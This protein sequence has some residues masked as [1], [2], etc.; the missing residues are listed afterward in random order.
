MNP[1]AR[2]EAGT[3]VWQNEQDMCSDTLYEDSEKLAARKSQ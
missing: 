1:K 2:V 3:V